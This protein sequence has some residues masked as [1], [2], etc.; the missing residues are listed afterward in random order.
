MELESIDP[1][2]AVELY[3]ADREP[4]LG[5]ITL[6]SHRR[7][8]ENSPRREH[9]RYPSFHSMSSMTLPNQS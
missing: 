7:L 9:D 1:E 3:L 6:Q 4:E 5:T 2:T 8:W